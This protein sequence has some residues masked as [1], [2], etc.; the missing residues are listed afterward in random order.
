V[1]TSADAT[2]GK[3]LKKIIAVH[4]KRHGISYIPKHYVKDLA[5]GVNIISIILEGDRRPTFKPNQKV[6]ELT[7]LAFGLNGEDHMNALDF[8]D[9]LN[10]ENLFIHCEMGIKRSK[11]MAQWLQ[12]QRPQY[13]IGCHTT[14]FCMAL[15]IR[16]D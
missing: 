5:D 15:L 9:E 4:R 7:D 13:R 12:Y 11:N 16:K 3:K 1:T 2:Q 8:L 6:L 10:G 14:D